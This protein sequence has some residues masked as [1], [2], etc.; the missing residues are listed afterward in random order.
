MMQWLNDETDE[1]HS[2]AISF[3]V[4]AAEMVREKLLQKGNDVIGSTENSSK[5]STK[6]G[7]GKKG[8][9]KGS[10]SKKDHG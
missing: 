7:G 3:N 6:K 8:S 4:A 5:G 10:A 2:S 9:D 1:D